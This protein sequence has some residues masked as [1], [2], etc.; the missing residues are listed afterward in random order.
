MFSI[1]LDQLALTYR[2]VAIAFHRE[3]VTV[4]FSTRDRYDKTNL[5]QG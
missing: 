1:D 2:K 4:G 5:R 3:D